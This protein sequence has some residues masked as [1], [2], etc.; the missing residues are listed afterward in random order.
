[1]LYIAAFV[2]IVIIIRNTESTSKAL[3]YTFLVILYPVLGMIIYF[4]LGINYRSRKI[5]S[6]KLVVDNNSFPELEVRLGKFSE[7]MLLKNREHLKH[8][9]RL[10]HLKNLENLLTVRNSTDLL[11]NGEQKFEEVLQSLKT[12]KHHIHIEYYIYEE[13]G[14]GQEIAEILKTKAEEGVQV[15]FIYDDFGSQGISRGFV[16]SLKKSGVEVFPFYK[17]WWHLFTTRINYRNHRKIIVV[18]GTVGYVGGINV[19]DRYV[20]TNEN[21]GF[22]RDTHLRIEGSAVLLLQRVFLADWNFCSDQNIGVSPDFFPR[23]DLSKE[24][25]SRQIVQIVASGPDSDHPDIMYSMMQ[26]IILAKEEV[27]ITTP[28]FVP[29]K[30]IIN[31]LK[32]AKLSGVKVKLLVPGKSDSK[33]VNIVSKSFYGELLDIGVEIYR[34]EKGFVHAK[35]MVCD[36]LLSMIGTANF[37]QRSFELNFEINALIF[38]EAFSSKLRGAF[39]KD[40]QGA[41]RISREKWEKRSHIS[42]IAERTLRLFAPLI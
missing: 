6:K 22:W 17:L 13:I 38:D 27:L 35:T 21:Y 16:R 41:K 29:E 30:G 32:I 25:V 37:D 10:A 14:I 7:E 39:Y 40:L 9:F 3:A 23:I 5:Y 2:T 1:M 33:V 4:S 36:N 28:Y 18:D 42:K 12:A 34:Y 8:F 26:A 15:R 20:N 11:I 24:P 31:A 19:S